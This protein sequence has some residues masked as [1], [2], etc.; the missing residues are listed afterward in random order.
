[1]QTSRYDK[2]M[3]T[4]GKRLRSA[5]ERGGFKSAQGFSEILGVEPHTYRKYE[6]GQSEPNF[7]ILVRICELLHV[8]TNT[9]LPVEQ[10]R[11]R[12]SGNQSA[13]A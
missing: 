5:R 8:D 12:N 7:E 6:R 10:P 2:I 11:K 3:K 13:A 4:F 9:L 1:M